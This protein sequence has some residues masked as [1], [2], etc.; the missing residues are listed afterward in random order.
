M[1]IKIMDR[2]IP[3][4]RS[5]WFTYLLEQGFAQFASIPQGVAN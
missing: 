3:I 1:A 5:L 4:F 2:F